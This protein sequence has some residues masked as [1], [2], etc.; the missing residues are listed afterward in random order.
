ML[1]KKN[2]EEGSRKPQGQTDQ[3][4]RQGQHSNPAIV[5][6]AP[7]PAPDVD[8]LPFFPDQI[9]GDHGTNHNG[10]CAQQ[11]RSP[12]PRA[13]RTDIKHSGEGEWQDTGCQGSPTGSADLNAPI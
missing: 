12:G 10:N 9:D 8:G 7:D 3:C 11:R 5:L 1:L 2:I 13:L 6:N 4:L